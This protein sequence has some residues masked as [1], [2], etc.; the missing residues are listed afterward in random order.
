M[1]R[2]LGKEHHY[3]LR[4]MKYLAMDYYSEFQ[5]SKVSPV[6]VTVQLISCKRWASSSVSYLNR[7]S[8]VS[9]PCTPRIMG[10]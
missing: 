8:L 7:I 10:L 5:L 2:T 3:T 6:Y 4:T 9:S 1:V